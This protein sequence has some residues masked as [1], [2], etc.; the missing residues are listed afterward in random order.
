MKEFR[1]GPVEFYLVGFDGDR[2]DPS[3]FGALTDLVSKGVV[4]VLDLV[5]VTR[6][7]D[8]D[9]DILEVEEDDGAAVLDGLEPIVAGLASE[10]DVRALAEVVPPGRSAAVVVLELLFAR[11]L[12]Q[13][14]AAAGGQVLRSERVPAPVVN[15]VMD[16][17][18][19]EGE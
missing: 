14:V 6:T 7:A 4:R 2:P 16:I 1:F 19:Q 5:L 3:T 18:E 13:D 11:T 10:D 8:G 9:L 17:L 15:A 12:A